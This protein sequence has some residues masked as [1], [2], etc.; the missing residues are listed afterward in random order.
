METIAPLMK[1]PIEI[2]FE[3]CKRVLKNPDKEKDFTYEE[4]L[5]HLTEDKVMKAGVDA[6]CEAMEIYAKLEKTPT[7]HENI[8]G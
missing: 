8:F 1:L 4:F 6:I 3:T 5:Q 7:K 2:F